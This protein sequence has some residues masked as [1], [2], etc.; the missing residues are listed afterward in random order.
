MEVNVDGDL[1]GQVKDGWLK[2]Q[3]IHIQ[4]SV[5]IGVSIHIQANVITGVLIHTNIQI[6][7]MKVC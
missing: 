4:V 3:L 5:G 7:V 2:N 6:H 1:C